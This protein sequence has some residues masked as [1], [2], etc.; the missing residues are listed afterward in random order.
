MR[1]KDLAYRKS[2]AGAKQIDWRQVMTQQSGISDLTNEEVEYLRRKYA[3]KN[4]T[5]IP[6]VLGFIGIFFTIIFTQAISTPSIPFDQWAGYIYGF[7]FG[8]MVPGIVLV[9]VGNAK[10]KAELTRFKQ[11]RQKKVEAQPAEEAI[12]AKLAAEEEQRQRKIKEE[13]DRRLREVKDQ[14]RLETLKNLVEMSEEI[15]VEDLASV[16]KCPALTYSGKLRNGAS[17]SAS[18]SKGTESSSRNKMLQVSLP[19]STKK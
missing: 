6:C 14:Q 12:G 15:L 3:W 2:P 9:S 8:L 17:N 18:N 11:E 19:N 13:E 4:Y 5:P 10:W 7:F 1:Q 16:P